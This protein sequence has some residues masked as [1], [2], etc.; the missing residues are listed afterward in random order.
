GENAAL[1]LFESQPDRGERPGRREDLGEVGLDRHQVGAHPRSSR[2]LR[3]H[4][5]NSVATSGRSHANWTI[6]RRE[7]SRLPVSKRRPWNKTPRTPPPSAGGIWARVLS[8]SVTWIS[9]PRPGG[10]SRRT[11]K[12]AGSHT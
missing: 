6:V 1:G 12:M 9:P 11:P 10:V 2:Y 7:S 8:A 3:S 4:G 5:T